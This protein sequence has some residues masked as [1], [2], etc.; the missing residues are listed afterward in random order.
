MRL[1]VGDFESARRRNFPVGDEPGGIRGTGII[2]KSAALVSKKSRF[3]RRDNLLV[4]SRALL[5]AFPCD[6]L[7]I[8]PRARCRHVIDPHGVSSSWLSLVGCDAHGVSLTNIIT[9]AD[10]RC[11]E[12][13]EKL[14]QR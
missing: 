8:R 11:S 3:F 10:S 14:R 2:R 12:E 7:G 6:E 4:R 9:W 5:F 1:M 13:G